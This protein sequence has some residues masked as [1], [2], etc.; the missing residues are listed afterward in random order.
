ME[1]ILSHAAGG[2]PDG[3]VRIAP[4]GCM[5][6]HLPDRAAPVHLYSASERTS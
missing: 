4:D 3:L 2:A 1:A 5:T 6:L